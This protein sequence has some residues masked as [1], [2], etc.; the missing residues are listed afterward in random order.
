LI[1]SG[2]RIQ[3]ASFFRGFVAAASFARAGGTAFRLQV[4]FMRKP[5]IRFAVF[6]LYLQRKPG[7]PSIDLAGVGALRDGN[8]TIESL[9]GGA[10]KFPSASDVFACYLMSRIR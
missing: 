1:G 6:L 9:K 5:E 7:K 2:Q 4:M 8:L 3:I 10:G